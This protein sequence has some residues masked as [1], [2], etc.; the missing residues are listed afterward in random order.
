MSAE[1]QLTRAHGRANVCLRSTAVAAVQ[2]RELVRRVKLDI[3][4][5]NL[6]HWL[7]LRVPVLIVPCL[8]TNMLV[9]QTWVIRTV[10]PCYFAVRAKWTLCAPH[11]GC[12]SRRGS[13]VRI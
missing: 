1:Q 2:A 13:A 6:R 3:V 11:Y 12:R 4:L 7:L 8:Y 9:L 10:F 5:G